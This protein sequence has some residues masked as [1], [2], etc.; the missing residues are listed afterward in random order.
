MAKKSKDIPV[1]KLLDFVKEHSIDADAFSNDFII[2]IDTEVYENEKIDYLYRTEFFFV[3]LVLTGEIT[4]NI[5]NQD[6]IASKHQL[7]MTTPNDTKRSVHATK[8]AMISGVAFT[9]NFLGQISEIKNLPE[10]FNYI[11]YQGSPLWFPDEEDFIRMKELME[12]L[13][14]RYLHQSEHP[15]GKDI[16]KNLFNIFL[17]ELGGIAQKYAPVKNATFTRK[18]HLV[19][20]FV[21][22]LQKKFKE[23]RNVQY[24]A[25]ELNI[26]PKYLTQTV[27]EVSGKSA[28]ELIDDFVIQE[29]KLLLTDASLSISEVA[30][31]LHFSDQS[32]FGKFFK[33]H[34]GFSPSEFRKI[35]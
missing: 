14:F 23:H 4:L 16:L 10:V 27:K 18:E 34:T 19:M 5:N 6:Y 1:F 33:R 8:G 7:I 35:E 24:Y 28:G 17:Y 20:Q 12:H 32:F 26:N 31:I 9:P 22:M 3:V 13:S 11:S 30:D 29:S 2:K 21:N 25:N 15:F